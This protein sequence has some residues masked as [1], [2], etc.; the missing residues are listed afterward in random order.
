MSQRVLLICPM[1]RNTCCMTAA[2]EHAVSLE[3]DIADR[4]KKCL[5]VA[6][7]S[8]QDIADRLGVARNTVSSW[9][10]GRITPPL[11]IQ[12]LW[13]LEFAPYGVTLTWLQT[14]EPG[15]SSPGPG[16]PVVHRVGLEPTTR[17]FTPALVA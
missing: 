2:P 12:K 7:I 8:V 10:N 5:R 1:R 14:G 16:L 4:M 13:A 3:M 6:D 15:P 9:I 17:W 11:P